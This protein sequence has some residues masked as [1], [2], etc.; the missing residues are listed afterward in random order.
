[1]NLYTLLD[2]SG[3]Y[4]IYEPRS[5]DALSYQCNVNSLWNYYS[6]V[7]LEKPFLLTVFVTASLIPRNVFLARVT[8]IGKYNLLFSLTTI[9]YCSAVQLNRYLGCKWFRNKQESIYIWQFSLSYSQ[10]AIKKTNSPGDNRGADTP[11]RG[12]QT[13]SPACV[14]NLDPLLVNHRATALASLFL[15]GLRL[16]QWIDV[17]NFI[18]RFVYQAV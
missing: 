1:M 13:L 15:S 16:S 18:D 10:V 2:V 12:P 5:Q 4:S 3:N 14:I 9:H 17:K 7:G 8:L 11:S 6:D